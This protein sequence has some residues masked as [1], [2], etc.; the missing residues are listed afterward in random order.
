MRNMHMT[1]EDA[2][3]RHMYP[4]FDELQDYDFDEVITC[5]DCGHCFQLT[6]NQCKLV[7][8]Y[9]NIQKKWRKREDEVKKAMQ[10]ALKCFGVCETRGELVELADAPCDHFWE[11]E[12]YDAY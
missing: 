3:H 10:L 9:V 5:E 7:W 8:S 2:A 1:N 6:D 11:G 4:T 12:R